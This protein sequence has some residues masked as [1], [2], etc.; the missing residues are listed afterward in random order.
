[1][2]DL[3]EWEKDVVI[4]DLGEGY[5]VEDIAV[6]NGFPG[7]AVRKFVRSLD[8]DDRKV[9]YEEARGDLS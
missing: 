2:R 5:G 3:S 8:S 4:A 9:I 1:M 6:M 7:D